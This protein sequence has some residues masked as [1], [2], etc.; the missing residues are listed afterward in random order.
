MSKVFVEKTSLNGVLSITPEVQFE[1]FR[2]SYLET[3]NLESYKNE[4]IEL[5]FLQDD[6]SISNKNV[7]RGIHGDFKTWKLV[8]CIKGKVYL[9]VVNNDLKSEQYRKW[10]SFTLSGKNNR[11]IL[12]PPGFGNG[13]LV[14]SDYAIF[15]YKQTTYYDF[16]S[17]FTI[18]WDDSNFDFWWP[19]DSPITSNRDA[20]KIL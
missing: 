18:F 4:G 1:D 19:I 2:G 8:S 3:Y 7:L 17:Q 14:M 5:E 9:I 10:E 16:E 11:Q 12:I 15:H 6:F 13:H 20:G